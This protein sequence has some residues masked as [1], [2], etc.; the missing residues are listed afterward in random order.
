[1]KIK[2]KEITKG[3]AFE[4]TKKGD[5]ID[6]RAAEDLT[7]GYPQVS[8]RKRI[9]VDGVTTSYRDLKIENYLIPLGIAMELPKGYEAIMAPRSSSFKTWGITEANSFGVIDNSYCGDN[10]EW[11]LPILAFKPST[12]NKGDRVCQFRIQL[13]QKATIWQ[14]IKWLFTNKIE[15]VW[16]DSLGND[17]RSGFGST[18]KQ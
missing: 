16:V 12:I 18:G 14:K 10:D 2:V 3:C 5:W 6:L 9:T 17:D 1:M 11:K 13:S 4:A 15:F 7:T 8:S